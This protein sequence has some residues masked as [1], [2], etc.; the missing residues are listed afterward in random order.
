MLPLGDTQLV[1]QQRDLE[2]F[3]AR[4]MP[5]GRDQIHQGRDQVSED[6]SGHS[7]LAYDASEPHCR[8]KPRG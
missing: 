7:P 1:P 3:P 5:T 6:Q 2:V 4:R 8:G